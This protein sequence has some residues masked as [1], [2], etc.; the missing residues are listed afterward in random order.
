MKK[1]I[2]SL[3]ACT[4]FLLTSCGPTKADA[5]KYNDAFIAI[6]KT[7]TP[8][9]NAF[10][11]QIDGH[12]IDSLKVA[13]EAFA[14]KAKSSVEECSKMQPFGEKRDY[15]DA[16]MSYFNTIHS[17]AQ[18]EGKQMVTIMS[19]DTAQVTEEDVANVGKFAEKFDAE[20]AKVLKM[21]QEAQ[22]SFAK[23]WQFEIKED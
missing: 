7:L 18:N 3:A 15:L 1:L 10:I 14:A 8:A 12:N 19:K 17:L 16:C 4:A 9:Y 13:Y 2:L 21:A 11:D 23:E 20:Y 6:E 22:A 5:I